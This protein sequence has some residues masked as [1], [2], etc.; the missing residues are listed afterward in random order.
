MTISWTG[1]SREGTSTTGCGVARRRKYAS[2]SLS[3]V[4]SKAAAS[5][6]RLPAVL[7]TSSTRSGPA[8]LNRT[9]FSVPSIIGA[10][11]VSGTGSS[12]ISTS[13]MS[14][15]RSTKRRSRYFSVS[16]AAEPRSAAVMIFPSVD[17]GRPSRAARARRRPCLAVLADHRRA[18]LRDHD[19]R[20]IGVA[21]GDRRHD[22]GIDNAQAADAPH[23]QA[24]VHDGESIASH[25]A[26]PDRVKDRGA[27]LAG[28]AHQLLLALIVFAG[29]EF[30]GRETLQRAGGADAPRQADRLRRHAAIGGRGEIVRLD[31]RMR[32]GIGGADPH[33]AAA[34]RPQVAHRGGEGRE[35]MERLAE[36]VEAQGLNVIF[37][38][39]RLVGRIAFGEGAELAWRHRQ[40]SAAGQHI[41]QSHR[42]A[43]AQ[44]AGL[45]IQRARVA[46]LVDKAQLQMIL[47]VLADAGERMHHGDTVLLQQRRRP[48]AGQLEQMRRADRAGGEDKLAADRGVCQ[49]ALMG[50][51]DADDALVRK[52]DAGG[53]GSG[54][55]AQIAAVAH[56]LQKRLCRVPAHAALLVDRKVAA[57][58]VVAAIEIVGLGNAQFRR[59]LAKGVE[60]LPGKPHALDAPFAADPVK[61][62]GAADMILA[63][64]EIGKDVLPAPSYI[65]E[66]APLVV[67]ARLAAHIDHAVD[68]G[69]AAQHPPAR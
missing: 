5:R 2:Y 37:E 53:L 15:R 46:H 28:G 23:A 25:L 17:Q 3:G 22:R 11:A 43:A 55:N 44:S 50:E 60:D 35:R 61:R 21:R 39:W 57:A 42:D 26:G 4:V 24:L 59:R 38:V 64:L 20:R 52:A 9:A 30:F 36:F 69:A 29:A 1:A 48:D 56:R 68:R 6:R 7:A 18:F 47:Q 13:P 8:C 54:E 67:V 32:L 40:G 14:I 65:A 63:F 49:S 16:T 31:R 45:L 19:G 62:V 10:R 12:W 51:F 33:R 34:F 41:C 58:L 27:D 66:L